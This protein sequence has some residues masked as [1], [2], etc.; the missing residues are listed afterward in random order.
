M[1]L[2]FPS[3][4]LDNRSV[5]EIGAGRGFLSSFCAARGASMVIALEPEAAG[6][7]IGVQE[8][9]TKMNN[10]LELTHIV[11]YRHV[12]FDQFVNSY[13]GKPFDYILM[14][15]VINHLN[16]EATTLLHLVDAHTERE[17]FISTFKKMYGLLAPGG[18]LIASDVGRYNFWNAIGNKFSL[19]KSIE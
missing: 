7:T 2:H 9:F 17:I 12:T 19:T 15:A 3:L 10:A 16:E 11:D 18:A 1:D 14:C 8:E 13:A 4:P 5:L 6:S